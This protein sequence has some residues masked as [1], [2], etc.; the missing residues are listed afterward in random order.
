MCLDLISSLHHRFYLAE[1]CSK[2]P[3]TNEML[4]L[5]LI[6]RKDSFPRATSQ[7]T[8]RKNEFY[9][10]KQFVLEIFP[11]FYERNFLVISHK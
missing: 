2:Y 8:Q 6:K 10:Q 9:V 11:A 5:H 3:P 1:K 4:K 7:N